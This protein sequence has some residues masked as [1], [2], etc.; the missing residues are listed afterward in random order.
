MPV[1]TRA[2]GQRGCGPVRASAMAVGRRTR[3]RFAPG[4]AAPFSGSS[5][6]A[7]VSPP[8]HQH[9][10]ATRPPRAAPHSR[11]GATEPHVPEPLP[12]PAAAPAGAQRSRC[13]RRRAIPSLRL[14][15]PGPKSPRFYQ[16]A[17]RATE[18]PRGPRIQPR[19]ANRPLV[20]KTSVCQAFDGLGRATSHTSMHPRETRTACQRVARPARSTTLDAAALTALAAASW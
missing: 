15:S 7:P 2:G 11:P 1:S 8:R 20:P 19:T 13:S 17:V 9:C 6:G 14:G 10:R 18:F 3:P 12:W 16:F 4:I 5:K